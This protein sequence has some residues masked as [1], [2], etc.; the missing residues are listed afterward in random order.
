MTIGKKLFLL[1][2]IVVISFGLA[3]L[4][5][6]ILMAPI[7][8]IE[9]EEKILTN[10]RQSLIYE[11][12]SLNKM[13]TSIFE[14]AYNEFLD[15]D[16]EC[17][18]AFKQISSL[19]LLSETSKTIAKSLDVISQL[20][21]LIDQNTESVQERADTIISYAEEIFHF[22]NSFSL[23]S[24]YTSSIAKNHPKILV[25]EMELSSFISSV[26]ILNNSLATSVSVL[27][28][29]FSII[30]NEIDSIKRKANITALCI[31]FGLL[32]VSILIAVFI[33]RKIAVSIRSIE[34][35]IA[36]I[37]TGDLRK[38]ISVLSKDEIGRLGDNL[39][40]FIQTLTGTIAAI[41]ATS[42]ENVQVKEELLSTST[43]T[44]ATSRQI[45]AN[46]DSIRSQIENL[47][48]SIADSASA[49]DSIIQTIEKLNGQV[50]EQ[51]AMV[52]ES[53]ASVTEMISS[54]DSVAKNTE[55]SREATERL[56][57]TA[58][59]GGEK[60]RKTTRVVEEINES[61]ENIRGMT[62]II[63]SIAAQTN[64]LAMNAAIEAAHAGEYGRGFAVVADEIRKLAEASSSN[65]KEITSTLKA[66]V[67][68][69]EEAVTSG[70]DTN[71]AF[72]KINQEVA[73]VSRAL[74]EIFSNMSE[75][76]TGGDQILTAM[77][78]LQDVSANV[79]TGA[80]DM[81][82][83]T[84]LVKNSMNTVRRVS[85]EVSGSINE[86]SLGIKEISEAVNNLNVLSEKIGGS[87]D[88]LNR[89]VN[90]FKTA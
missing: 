28:E 63:Q 35:A 59:N 71:L 19:H 40:A 7:A 67:E 68:K 75:L 80:D 61:V 22:T 86:I 13:G 89:Q 24:F 12:V 39:N 3:I 50:Q 90:N 6:F 78:T 36:M 62:N 81:N 42:S 17:G 52:E 46:T 51:M 27:D 72:E 79:K 69:I 43:E 11:Q 21:K 25:A 20:R 66:I 64:L 73:S 37:K 26:D 10:L 48:S 14:R 29:Q 38:K 34:T 54:I 44:A 5:Y 58:D 18:N 49:T 88:N 47:D 2:T 84:G 32:I 85:S 1:L 76:R 65:S 55:K 57:T 33:A 45:S 70:Q 15:S 31:I 82:Q 53:T 4:S 77:V 87:S 23:S 8:E 41:Q 30:E 83:E 60:L 9:A 56:V 74:S 16:A